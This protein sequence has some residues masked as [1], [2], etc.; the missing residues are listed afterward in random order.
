MPG[1]NNGIPEEIPVDITNTRYD[2]VINS[3]K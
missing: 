2:D 3:Y 1:G